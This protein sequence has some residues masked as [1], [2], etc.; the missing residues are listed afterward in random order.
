MQYAIDETSLKALREAAKKILTDL[1]LERMNRREV[2]LGA[3]AILTLT[4]HLNPI[5]PKED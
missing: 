4:D 2:G 5:E 1:N 3:A